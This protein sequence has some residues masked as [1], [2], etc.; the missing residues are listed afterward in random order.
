MP[1]KA[2]NMTAA[3]AI[4]VNLVN[5]K[6]QN[7]SKP[8]FLGVTIALFSVG[9]LLG[10][11][12]F[13]KAKT[14]CTPISFPTPAREVQFHAK[15]VV[16]G[17]NFQRK[18]VDENFRFG[19]LPCNE[20]GT[21]FDA[22]AQGFGLPQDSVHISCGRGGSWGDNGMQDPAQPSG[23]A[24]ATPMFFVEKR[25]EERQRTSSAG[26]DSDDAAEGDIVITTTK[27]T[28]RIV[29]LDEVA[30][31]VVAD[32]GL[33]MA[34]V[35][36]SPDGYPMFHRLAAANQRKSNAAI[37]AHPQIGI[38]PC[39]PPVEF[40]DLKQLEMGGTTPKHTGVWKEESRHGRLPLC[41]DKDGT[42]AKAG[43][44]PF[45]KLETPSEP[46][47]Y[48]CVPIGSEGGNELPV[49]A[50]YRVAEVTTYRVEWTPRESCTDNDLGT[51]LG[52]SFGY[53]NYIEMF[54][55][56]VVIGALLMC[57]II[58]TNTGSMD[59]A[60][61]ITGETSAQTVAEKLEELA[62]R[63]VRLEGKEPG[64]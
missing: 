49:L 10:V 33:D 19:G 59:W 14:R 45:Y 9:I 11:F 41:R 7:F 21:M 44:E 8:L 2:K 12:F 43:G 55:T 17:F 31:F 27:R 18:Q 57:G 40:Y 3:Q 15:Q 34:T 1:P 47:R 4:V 25:T 5:P 42:L 24:A 48:E 32:Q 20:D 46:W 54:V 63:V 30:G 28:E 6:L 60:A 22:Y 39:N 26:E 62:E 53:A 64:A 23:I 16:G 50:N 58:K 38:W 29:C 51:A 36:Q 61:T 13:E 56:A 37:H 52:V 35:E